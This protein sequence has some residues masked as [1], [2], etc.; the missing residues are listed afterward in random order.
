MDWRLVEEEALWW[1]HWI[2]IGKDLLGDADVWR[3]QW[4]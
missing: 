4:A 2:W 1:R 3:L